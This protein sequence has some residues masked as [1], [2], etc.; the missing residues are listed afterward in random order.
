M[1]TA[2]FIASL[3]FLPWVVIAAA[4]ARLAPWTL[5]MASAFAL[6]IVLLVAMVRRREKRA[7][8]WTMPL[9]LFVLA[10]M[11][12]NLASPGA[13]TWLVWPLLVAAIAAVGIGLTDAIA[14]R[15]KPST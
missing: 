11:A 8:G 10:I 13:A 6:A 2:L 1:R 9:V 5:W 7:P 12:I 14:S 3:A 15:P 4:V